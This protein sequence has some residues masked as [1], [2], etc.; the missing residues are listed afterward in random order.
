MS[1]VSGHA[2]QNR[3]MVHSTDSSQSFRFVPVVSGGP[4]CEIEIDVAKQRANEQFESAA[5]TAKV[6]SLRAS[7]VEL[8][9]LLV[10]IA[11]E[12]LPPKWAAIHD[13]LLANE[14]MWV[15]PRATLG[16]YEEGNPTD[17]APFI[18]RRRVAAEWNELV[19]SAWTAAHR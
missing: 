9:L 19:K 6:D 7:V 2:K 13:A 15:Y 5:L 10:E 12:L 11:P 18:N 8:F 16:D 14:A 1:E 3:E 4:W 17:S